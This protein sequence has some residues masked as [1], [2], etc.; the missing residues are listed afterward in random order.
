MNFSD[1]NNIPTLFP[2]EIIVIDSDYYAGVTEFIRAVVDV[3]G[4]FG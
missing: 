2:I 3:C 4:L 1:K